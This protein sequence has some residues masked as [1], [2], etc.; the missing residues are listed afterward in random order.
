MSKSGT[1]AYLAPEVYSGEGYGPTADWWSLGVLFYECIYSKVRKHG[2]I[3]A[4]EWKLTGLQRPFEGNSESTLSEA[5]QAANPKW[6][7]TQPPVSLSCLYAIQAAMNPDPRRRMGRTWES[8]IRNDFFAIFDFEALERKEID[9]VFVP[10]AEKTNFDA[11]YDL[12][13]LLLEEAPL[14]ARARRQKPRDKLKED[15]TEQQIR[16]EELY[17]MI[18][19]DFL[20][21]D[22]TVAAYNKSV[23]SASC[24]LQ[25]LTVARITAMQADGT[26]VED[27]QG[28][29]ISTN[30]A[31]PATHPNGNNVKIYQPEPLH[32]Q[33]QRP[34]SRKGT[35]QRAPGRPAPLPPY[36]N[37]YT[38]GRNARPSGMRVESSTGGMQVTLDSAGSWSQLARQDATLPTD[39]NAVNGDEKAAA[40]SGGVFGLFGRKKGRGHSPKPKE[41]GVLGKEGARVIIN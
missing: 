16:E 11:T 28:Q 25:R 6:H 37:S 10:S 4:R 27:I 24:S 13:E 30:A 38:T 36:P 35:G 23:G 1:L 41:R 3:W 9:P 22:Y 8:F 33:S 32:L 17:Q 7:V 26:I 34:V 20:P 12:E 39:A 5:V 21:F 40:S 14:E 31:V 18:E 2:I 19:R 29:A 15:A